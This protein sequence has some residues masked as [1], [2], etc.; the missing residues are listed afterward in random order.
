MTTPLIARSSINP[1]NLESRQT[2]IN[3]Y[4][5]LLLFAVH[6]LE[7]DYFPMTPRGV[8]PDS[9]AL[10]TYVRAIIPALIHLTAPLCPLL[11]SV[12]STTEFP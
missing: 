9:K 8:E 5:V 2:F 6:P 1:T 11:D 12:K 3:L 4:L 7:S 10:S